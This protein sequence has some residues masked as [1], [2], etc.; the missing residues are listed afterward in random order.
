MSNP[1]DNV[2]EAAVAETE[3]KKRYAQIALF[4]D[5][6]LPGGFTVGLG[7]LS[8]QVEAGDS[9]TI[10]VVDIVAMAVADILAK[11]PPEFKASIDRAVAA[12]RKTEQAI[13][14][15]A[16]PVEAVRANLAEYGIEVRGSGVAS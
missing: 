14:G 13:A 1:A 12:V 4:E 5:P 6:K 11:M 7:L 8:Q 3:P 9:A 10:P 16:D 2:A 15:G